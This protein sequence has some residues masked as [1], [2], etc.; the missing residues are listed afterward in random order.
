MT[1][2]SRLTN[3]DTGSVL[4][5][6]HEE[7]VNGHCFEDVGDTDFESGVAEDSGAIR[8]TAWKTF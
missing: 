6:V 8:S 4:S 2:L 7:W 1:V 5:R 3:Q